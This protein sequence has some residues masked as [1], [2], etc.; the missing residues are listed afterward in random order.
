MTTNEMEFWKSKFGSD[1]TD[2]NSYTVPDLDAFYLKEW[3]ITRTAMNAAMLGD[4]ALSRILEVG[5]NVGNQLRCLQAMGFRQLYGIELQ[6]Y[7]VERAKALSENIN[8]IQGSAFDLP[9]KDNYFDMVFTSGVLIHISEADL[10]AVMD[11]IYRS[12]SKYIWGFEYFAETHQEINYRGNSAKLWK[13]NFAQKYLDRFPSLRLVKRA[14]FKYVANAN[15]DQMF[16]LEKT[17]KP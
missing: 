13:G 9:F 5:C 2:R 6:G 1:Y 3:G 14:N 11:E 7:A 8:I 10:P 15:C 17:P 12:T 4:I 16:L